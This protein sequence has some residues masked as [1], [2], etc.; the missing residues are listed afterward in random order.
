MCNKTRKWGELTIIRYSVREIEDLGLILKLL[1]L[2]VQ[3][4]FVAKQNLEVIW[5]I[6]DYVSL[7][8]LIY[9][10]GV[11]AT[12]PQVN[13]KWENV[14]TMSVLHVRTNLLGRVG[15]NRF[16]SLGHSLPFWLA[17]IRT[18]CYCCCKTESSAEDLEAS[19]RENWTH[20]RG[21]K[22]LMSDFKSLQ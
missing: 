21:W 20:G 8:E 18:L 13:Q 19:C 12:N 10:F 3:S 4:C 15:S 7:P 16:L 17:H 6:A 14:I 22:G 5:F 2:T 1:L 11:H 9:I